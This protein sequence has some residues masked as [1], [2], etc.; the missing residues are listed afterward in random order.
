MRFSQLINKNKRK[1]VN[2][3]TI[4]RQQQI[5]SRMLDSQKSM[6]QKDYSKKRNSKAGVEFEYSGPSTLSEQNGNNNLL[7][8]Q[9]MF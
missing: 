5:L 1:D 2:K 8:I 6:Q 3:N 4:D 9:S 7:L